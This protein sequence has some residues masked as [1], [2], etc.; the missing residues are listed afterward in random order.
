MLRKIIKSKKIKTPLIG[1]ELKE[2]LARNILE[3]DISIV[4][5]NAASEDQDSDHNFVFLPKNSEGHID[6]LDIVVNGDIKNRVFTLGRHIIQTED[7]L[8]RLLAETN[9]QK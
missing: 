9:I 4:S 1:F 2:Q 3:N 7:K 5:V 6:S 8:L